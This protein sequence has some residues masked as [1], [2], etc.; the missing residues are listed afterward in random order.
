MS[1]PDFLHLEAPYWLLL[2]IPLLIGA[3]WSTRGDRYL[4]K[5][6]RIRGKLTQTS[7]RPALPR[8]FFILA[9]SCIIVA[10]S[11]PTRRFT[12]VKDD[13]TVNRI[14]VA[15]DNSSSM[16]NFES[17]SNINY[18]GD[19]DVDDVESKP[20]Y[21]P[22]RCTDT[23]L[24]DKYPRIYVACS[25]LHRILDDVEAFVRKKGNNN[26][27]DRVGLIRWASYSKVQ[28]Y[29][30]SDFVGLRAKIDKMNWRD[31]DNLY[32]FTEIHLG[33]WDLFLM[34][35]R[36]NRDPDGGLVYLNKQDMDALA[37]ALKPE[38]KNV[39]FSPPH[40]LK[41][42]F[43]QLK[44]ELRDTFF[45]IITDASEGQ[46]ESRFDKDPI[47]FKKMAEFAALLELPIYIISTELANPQF[48]KLMLKTGFGPADGK[49]RGDFFVVKQGGGDGLNSIETLISTILAVRFGRTVSIAVERRESYAWNLIFIALTFLIF[50]S[51][52]KE[53][54]SRSLTEV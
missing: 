9:L 35:F 51:F 21:P 31:E 28:A 46:L 30:T 54:L 41:D 8:I 12:S 43:E 29:P 25:A 48:K 24:K 38:G 53:T 52:L 22:I 6:M 7:F 36:R 39:S 44:N 11:D 33:L 49:Y 40:T 17:K 4:L 50:G 47:S 5:S 32:I 27:V 20:K 2:F 34:A 1:L 45:I 13:L 42:K 16:Y 18:E 37:S 19:I 14:F 3:V 23:N 10:L 26:Q 15:I